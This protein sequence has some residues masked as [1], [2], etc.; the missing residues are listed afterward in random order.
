L[1]PDRIRIDAVIPVCN[2]D[3][4]EN[5]I[6]RL[7]CCLKNHCPH[8]WHIVIAGNGSTDRVPE[9]A[10]QLHA[11]WPKQVDYF[12]TSKRGQGYALRLAWLRSDAEV[13]SYMVVDLATDLEAFMP[14]IE[15]LVL[16]AHHIA[17][18]S[19]LA[20]GAHV[21]RS[22]LRRIMS[23][24]YNIF[25]KMLFPRRSFTD[26]QC[27]FKAITRHAVQ[28]IIPLVKNNNWFFDPE[29]LL[30]A[31]RHNYLIHEVPVRWSDDSD[32]TVRISKTILELMIG[33]FRVRLSTNYKD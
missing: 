32:A 7:H 16:G 2:E 8:D 13:M 3:G 27:G 30:L 20:K 31:E 4:L 17:V 29:L 21:Q 15:P 14:L 23:R 1:E 28:E 19:R 10:Q 12:S 11:R 33:L 5:S 24:I 22:V 9:I 25:I 18:G 6:A 26:A